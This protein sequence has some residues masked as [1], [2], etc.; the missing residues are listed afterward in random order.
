MASARRRKY[1]AANPDVTSYAKAGSL[2]KETWT[3]TT[4][5]TRAL[6]PQQKALKKIAALKKN[7]NLDC[8]QGK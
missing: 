5:T 1:M 4:R 2:A 3:K 7:F 8:T 6:T